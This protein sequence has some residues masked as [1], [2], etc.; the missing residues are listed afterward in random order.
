MSPVYVHL[1][2]HAQQPS[3]SCVRVWDGDLT[4][5]K[6]KHKPGPRHIYVETKYDSDGNMEMELDK[7]PRGAGRHKAQVTDQKVA[8]HTWAMQKA[9]EQLPHANAATLS[10]LLIQSRGTN[11]HMQSQQ[12]S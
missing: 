12:P 4:S 3:R 2:R 7:M 11:C 8:M 9:T 10:M 1:K 5:E 6:K